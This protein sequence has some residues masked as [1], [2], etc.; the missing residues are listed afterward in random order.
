MPTGNDAVVFDH[1]FGGTYLSLIL[2]VIFQNSVS[3]YS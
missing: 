1:S 3:Y 2:A